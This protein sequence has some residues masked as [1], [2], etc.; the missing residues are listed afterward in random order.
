ME[1][2]II[3]AVQ[4]HQSE[5]L[6]VWTNQFILLLVVTIVT[7]FL[8]EV[9]SNVAQVIVFAPVV[10]SLADAIGMNPLMLGIAMTLA[11]SCASMLPMGTPPNAIVFASGHI[12]LRQMTRAG[13]VVNIVSVVLIA[14]FSWF[15][16]PVLLRL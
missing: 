13:F 16:L 5:L 1:K 4:V 3:Y 2:Q 15:L 12:K 8:S 9:M 6:K 10:S 7:M 11:A 14:L